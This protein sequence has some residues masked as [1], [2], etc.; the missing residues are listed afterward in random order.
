M[1]KTNML[2]LLVAAGCA[3]GGI[4]AALAA[5]PEKVATSGNPAQ[6]DAPQKSQSEKWA[7]LDAE[8]AMLEKQVKIAELR[9]KLAEY[10]SGS[11]M[12][13]PSVSAAPTAQSLAV[14]LRLSPQ[15]AMVPAGDSPSAMSVERISSSD[16]RWEALLTINGRS[17]LP[18]VVGDTVDGGWK[19]LR[20]DESG[21]ELGKGKRTLLLRG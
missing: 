13:T 14:P 7:E 10:G 9:K 2:A 4:N 21:V 20:I 8:A 17:G 12:A 6:V 11:P 19:V 18:F 5:T 1:V 15:A 3:I 16:G